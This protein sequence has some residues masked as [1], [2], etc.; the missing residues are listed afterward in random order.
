MICVVGMVVTEQ[1]NQWVR[2]LEH[3]SLLKLIYKRWVLICPMTRH[4]SRSH[5]SRRGLRRPVTQTYSLIQLLHSSRTLN[6]SRVEHYPNL[7]ARQRHVNSQT[8]SYSLCGRRSNYIVLCHFGAIIL[9][10][11]RT[12]S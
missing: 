5:L 1:R 12:S 8:P 3:I 4:K 6:G 11:C 9:K 7:R 10:N 2:Q